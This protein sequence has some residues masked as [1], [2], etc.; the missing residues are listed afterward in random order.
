MTSRNFVRA[1]VITLGLFGLFA[2]VAPA[3]LGGTASVDQLATIT[4]TGD[5]LTI[6]FEV[7]MAE[8]PSQEIRKT[9]D[10]LRDLRLDDREI[11]RGLRELARD[12]G[13]GL[14]LTLDGQPLRMKLTGR[15]VLETVDRTTGAVPLKIRFTYQVALPADFQGGTL[16]FQNRLYP[17]RVGFVRAHL[18]PGEGLFATLD[19]AM[20]RELSQYEKLNA[21]L[22]DGKVPELPAGEKPPQMRA[23]TWHVAAGEAPKGSGPTGPTGTPPAGAQAAGTEPAAASGSPASST[24]S[25][26]AFSDRQSRKFWELFS[27]FDQLST[28]MIIGFVLLAFVYGMGHALTPGHGKAITAAFLVGNK[29]TIRDA[30]IL[31][32]TVTATHTAAV[33]VLGI[34]AELATATIRRDK[35][36]WWLELTSALLILGLGLFIFFRYLLA[37][38]SGREVGHGHVHLFGGGHHHHDHAPGHAHDHAHDHPHAHD[39]AHDHLHAHTHDHD[40]AHDHDHTHGHDHTYDHE[41]TTG[42]PQDHDH[43]HDHAP[44]HPQDHDHTHDHAPG[45]PHPHE[46][47]H[48]PAHAHD[49]AHDHDHEHTTGHPQDHDHAHGPEP[50]VSA[51]PDRPRLWQTIYLGITG[52]MIPCP[53]GLVIISVSYQYHLLGFGLFLAAVFSLGMA[54]V[55]ISIG[56]LTVKGFKVAERYGSRRAVVFFRVMPVLSG[57]FIALLGL[58]FL[59][60]VMGWVH[61]SFLGASV[62]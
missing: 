2:Q 34:A 48:G 21:V 43:T 5:H 1:A 30:I 15:P 7:D 37:L 46:H 36:M 6:V 52:G 38:A 41:H 60:A 49:H 23:M 56:I 59:A 58:A 25:G 10:R 8:F 14:A 39:H 62:V 4:R 35:V 45:H 20:A 44:G 16:V 18:D 47:D 57:G 50:G 54:A 22:I 3:H 11:Q 51:H 27:Q 28:W 24:A 42:H 32:L 13:R 17:D 29:G 19:P 12:V 9:F 53:T 26:P 40:H 31:G 33:F 55:L 61:W